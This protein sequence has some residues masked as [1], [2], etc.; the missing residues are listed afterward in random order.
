MGKNLKDQTVCFYMGYLAT[1]IKHGDK[2]QLFSF[3][4]RGVKSGKSRHAKD[5]KYEI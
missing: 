2:M 3:K 1:E 5:N 4:N